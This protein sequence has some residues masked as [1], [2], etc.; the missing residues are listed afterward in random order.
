MSQ[1][2]RLLKLIDYRLKLAT[3]NFDFVPCGKDIW[4]MNPERKEWILSLNSEGILKYNFKFF[5]EIFAVFSLTW[6][7]YQGIL[8]N[9]VE[10]YFKVPIRQVQRVGGDLSWI[11]EKLDKKKKRWEMDSRFEFSYKVVKEYV[12][13]R[14]IFKE[15]KLENYFSESETFSTSASS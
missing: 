11:F 6:K 5:N 12:E 3:K 9:W 1:H 15:V 10:S 8:K 13:K 7:E 4:I 14:D 2:P